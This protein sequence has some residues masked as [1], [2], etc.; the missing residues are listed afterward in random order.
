MASPSCSHWE[1][2]L[3][4]WLTHAFLFADTKEK[5]SVSSLGHPCRGTRVISTTL[6]NSIWASEGEFVITASPEIKVGY[7]TGSQTWLFLHYFSKWARNFTCSYPPS[8]EDTLVKKLGQLVFWHLLCQ[9]SSTLRKLLLIT[10]LSFS[11]YNPN[12]FLWFLQQACEP[13]FLN[14]LSWVK[15]WVWLF[16][17][18]GD[19]KEV[20]YLFRFHSGRDLASLWFPCLFYKLLKWGFS[21]LLLFSPSLILTAS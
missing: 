6:S 12:I 4:N 11:C 17:G 3:L 14:E 7:H 20:W 15:P 16:F 8:G 9:H 19:K 1:A 5:G 13:K 21:L 2:I 18:A 10:N